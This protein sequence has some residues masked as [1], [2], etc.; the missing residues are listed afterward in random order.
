MLTITL[1]KNDYKI[2]EVLSKE[3]G[4]NKPIIFRENKEGRKYSS[5]QISSNIICNDLRNLGLGNNKTY[6]NSIANIDGKYMFDLIRGYIDGDGSISQKGENINISG[7]KTNL[8]KI[9]DFCEQFGIY[10]SFTEDKRC[11]SENNFHDQFG[12]LSFSNKT[13]VYCLSKMMYENCNDCFL[14]RKKSIAN[15]IINKIEISDKPS[16]KQIL[17][18]YNYVVKFLFNSKINN[19]KAKKG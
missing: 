11:Y 3:L 14:E 15:N 1:Q 12:L 18:Y 2:L 8:F 9:K 7:Y 13:S 16:D 5:I 19:Y 10:S 17:L 4:T 6:G